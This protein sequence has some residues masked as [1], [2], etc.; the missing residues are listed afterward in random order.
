[1]DVIYTF[2]IP[3]ILG[4]IFTTIFLGSLKHE[5]WEKTELNNFFYYNRSPAKQGGVQTAV[6]FITIAIPVKEQNANMLTASQ[7]PSSFI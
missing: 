6:F 1:M 4:G 3:G 7:M 5:P 2:G